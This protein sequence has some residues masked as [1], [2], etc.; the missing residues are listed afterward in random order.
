[1]KASTAL[2]V[3]H[4]GKPLLKDWL[5]KRG[6]SFSNAAKRFGIPA[7]KGILLIGVQGCG[8]SLIAKA[9]SRLS[10]FKNGDKQ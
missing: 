8:K 2:L 1:M 9:I 6:R 5:D 4:H 7:P 10:N 3:P